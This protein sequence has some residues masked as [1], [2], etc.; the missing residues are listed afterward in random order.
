MRSLHAQHDNGVPT[1]PAEPR[2]VKNVSCNSCLLNKASATPRN[3]VACAK[4]PLPLM[5][6]SSDIWEP[7]NV[8]SQHGLRYCLLVFDHHTNFMW[9]RFLKSKDDTC[10]ELESILLEVRHLHAQYHH[11]F[12]A[13]APILKF[14]SNSVFELMRHVRCAAAWVLEFISL[15]PTLIICLERRSVH[16]VPFGTTP[17]P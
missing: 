6:M 13:F 10:S 2:S 12:G 15:H 8:P 16:G 17:L 5:N 1:L 3:I 14:D 4:P 11:A 9:V 7:V